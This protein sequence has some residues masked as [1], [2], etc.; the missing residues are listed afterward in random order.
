MKKGAI[1]LKDPC[2]T[3]KSLQFSYKNRIFC[4]NCNDLSNVDTAVEKTPN[5]EDTISDSIDFISKKLQKTII[6]LN[7]EED[8]DILIKITSLI[9]LY[10]DVIH[11]MKKYSEISE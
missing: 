3:C 10:L 9:S 6:S 2:N 5:K 1:L 7:S 8:I 11:K 4:I